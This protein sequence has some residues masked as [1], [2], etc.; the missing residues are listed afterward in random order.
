MTDDEL[1]M[2]MEMAARAERDQGFLGYAKPPKNLWDDCRRLV[3]E[4]LVKEHPFTPGFFMPTGKGSLRV[5]HRIHR[6]Q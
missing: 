1:L 4:R 6:A 2:G 5:S 3:K